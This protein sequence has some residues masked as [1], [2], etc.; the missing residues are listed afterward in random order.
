M[1]SPYLHLES[2]ECIFVLKRLNLSTKDCKCNKTC[3]SVFQLFWCLC[4]SGSI[5][6]EMCVCECEGGWKLTHSCGC[7]N[8]RKQ[9][10][11]SCVFRVSEERK[12]IQGVPWF[13]SL[14]FPSW[15]F[16]GF[17]LRCCPFLLLRSNMHSSATKLLTVVS[18]SCW[19][20]QPVYCTRTYCF[21][22][23]GERLQCEVATCWTVMDLLCHPAA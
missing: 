22:S 18:Q 23:G 9:E 19:V 5:R 10:K 3:L 20:S 8:S 4:H 21:W 11:F 12:N 13:A 1:L 15:S 17:A 16:I 7:M 14:T 6:L 2:N